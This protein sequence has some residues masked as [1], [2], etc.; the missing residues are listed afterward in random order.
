MLGSEPQIYFY[1]QRRSATGYLYTYPLME[2][3]PFARRM[4]EEMIREIESTQPEFVVLVL[5]SGWAL[6][7]P[8]HV[9]TARESPQAA[10]R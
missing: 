2:P 1:S 4:Q 10:L 7:L 5:V 3:Q 8:E 6:H 9:G